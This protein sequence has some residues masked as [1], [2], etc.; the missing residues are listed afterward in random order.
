MTNVEHEQW[1]AAA[2][3]VHRRY[4]A[5]REIQGLDDP[6]DILHTLALG[7]ELNRLS[8]AGVYDQPSELF[9]YTKLEAFFSIMASGV[10]RAAN[11]ENSNDGREGHY[12]Q[13]QLE[14]CLEC[15][16][17]SSF[18]GSRRS[19]FFEFCAKNLL[20][21]VRPQYYVACFSS[22]E[23]GRT[24]WDYGG[25]GR[26]V[27][28]VMN[29]R[30]LHHEAAVAAPLANVSLRPIM[31]Q[32]AAQLEQLRLACHITY[33]TL[34]RRVGTIKP[35]DRDLAFI[36][37]L[38]AMLCSHLTWQATA[39][40]CEFW[41]DEREW[42]M[43]LP[44]FGDASDATVIKAM[45]DG[46]TYVEL[47]YPGGK[48]PITRVIVGPLVSAEDEEKVRSALAIQGYEAEVSRSNA[49]FRSDGD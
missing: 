46:R 26:G 4:L 21:R 2:D 12:R 38:V 31:Y 16:I 32:R 22:R 24:E 23:D 33:R 39:F 1:M 27:I 18:P 40:K 48:L 25:H 36:N 35:A 9:H 34:I 29:V 44:L 37:N 41:E 3:I 8:I 45:P 10:M 49:P 13:K 47:Q 5:K 43:T 30:R 17:R 42:R 19:H 14:D 28:V 15:Q 20:A 7:L 6:A 11:A